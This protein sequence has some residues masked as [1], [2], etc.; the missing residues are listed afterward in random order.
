MIFI[1]DTEKVVRIQ[2]VVR[3]MMDHIIVRN[4]SMVPEK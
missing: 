4:I 1:Y 2:S 3:E